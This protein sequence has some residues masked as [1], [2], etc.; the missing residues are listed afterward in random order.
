MVLLALSLL[1]SLGSAGLR[2]ALG[3]STWRARKIIRSL[4][5]DWRAGGASHCRS[6]SSNG[7]LGYI[8]SSQLCRFQCSRHFRTLGGP[9]YS[10][11]SDRCGVVCGTIIRSRPQRPLS[12]SVRRGTANVLGGLRS[13]YRLGQFFSRRARSPQVRIF[14]R[15]FRLGR[16]ARCALQVFSARAA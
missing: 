3:S 11:K 15:L 10:L 9:N 13:Q 14:T 16:P 4:L 8:G 12:S 6:A 5:A 7:W 1:W 2:V